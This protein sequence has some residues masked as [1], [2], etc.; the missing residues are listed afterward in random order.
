MTAT[1]QSP[2]LVAADDGFRQIKLLGEGIRHTQL[3]VARPGFSLGAALGGDA[4]AGG[5]R[6]QDRDYT[7]NAD[8]EGEDTRFDDYALSD[9]NRVLVHHALHSAGLSGREVILATGLPFRLYFKPDSSEANHELLQRKVANL[10][11]P[12][13]S[14]AGQTSPEIKGQAVYAQGLMAFIDYAMGDDF[15]LREGF[16]PAAPVTVIDVGGRTTDTATVIRASTVDH[17]ASGTVNVG[18]SNIQDH[19]ARSLKEEFKVQN[20]RTAMLDHFLRSGVATFRGQRMDIRAHIKKAVDEV[21]EQVRRE[22]QRRVGDAAEMQAVLLVGGGASL[23]A[24]GLKQ[25][26]PHLVVPEDPEFANARGMLK[27]LKASMTA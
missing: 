9:I 20:I 12:V 18:V 3:S 24:E 1:Q 23:L 13:E 4:G 11:V 22:L 17:A 8:I 10:A 16:D 25:D 19:L 26:Y 27:S 5:Y 7:V 14:L 21:L 6:T 2:V 15:A